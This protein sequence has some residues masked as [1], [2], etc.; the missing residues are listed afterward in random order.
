[1]I[2]YCKSICVVNDLFDL[3]WNSFDLHRKA[4]AMAAGVL[5]G[6]AAEAERVG[7]QV[8][9]MQRQVERLKRERRQKE[10]EEKMKLKASQMLFEVPFFAI[11][12]PFQGV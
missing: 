9:Q 3:E 2:V 8:R 11:S 7:R 12:R 6:S 5:R 10:E 1:M 4:E